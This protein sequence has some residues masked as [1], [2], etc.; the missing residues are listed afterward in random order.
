MA[1]DTNTSAPPQRPDNVPEKFWDAEK[2][3]VNT[4]ALLKGYSELSTKLGEDSNQNA[5]SN[6]Q[7]GIKVEGQEGNQQN[8]GNESDQ[9][10]GDDSRQKSDQN[11]Q[12]QQS[13]QQNQDGQQQQAP[14]EFA[15]YA[16]EY[17]R[18]GELS[19]E[20]YKELQEKNGL[21]KEFVDNYIN[22]QNQQQQQQL[23]ALYESVGGEE[24]YRKMTA[25]AEKNFTAREIVAF[26]QQV[27]S[28]DP[29]VVKLAV[30]ALA[31]A[32][33]KANGS[34]PNLIG[35]D[36]SRT[37]IGRFE[38]SSQV[39]SAMQDPRYRADPAYRR[40]VEDKVANSNVFG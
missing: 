6:N 19:E 2:G 26:D 1:E 12:D 16:E 5:A 24:N 35:G 28:N 8:A 27:E 22:L 13:Q 23:T 37:S 3:A 34:S 38:N 14:Q 25:W 9:N 17:A 11:Q 7:M 10:Q 20:S 40:E 30:T 4:D 18:A 32:Y 15:K 39:I 31:A 36:T 29:N 33:Q 21:S